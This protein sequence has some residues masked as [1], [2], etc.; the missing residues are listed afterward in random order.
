MHDLD[1]TAPY[2]GAGDH[3]A[4]RQVLDPDPVA[5]ATIPHGLAAHADA[6]AV[7][8]R[9][10]DLA[11]Y[12]R[13]RGRPALVPSL[14]KFG[15]S[16]RS[17]HPRGY[18]FDV[19]ELEGLPA[20]TF[21]GYWE[22]EGTEALGISRDPFSRAEPSIRHRW[23]VASPDGETLIDFLTQAAEAAAF[24]V[25]DLVDLR[26]ADPADHERQQCDEADERLDA[27]FG[28]SEEGPDRV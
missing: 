10:G 15:A 13:R 14:V 23:L 25:I 5:P 16:L 18:R 28:R 8:G 2:H 9:D 3:A 20:T 17:I 27:R 7:A 4:G 22:R 11:F 6:Q 1:D 21:E 26:D 24:D 12:V 19:A